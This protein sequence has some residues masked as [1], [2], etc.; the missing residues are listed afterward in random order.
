MTD[1]IV[2]R[3]TTAIFVRTNLEQFQDRLLAEGR[4]IRDRRRSDIEELRLGLAAAEAAALEEQARR[5]RNQITRRQR[6]VVQ[7]ENI[8][9]ALEAGF[10]PMPRLP[11]V[12]L[13]HVLGLIP[14]SALLA[15]GAAKETGLF[16]VFR[17][18]DGRNTDRTGWPIEWS[19]SRRR[20]RD[21]I[22]VGM[23]GQ[24]MFPLAWWK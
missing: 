11:A 20:S 21:P 7:A 3:P 16:E 13:H 4:Q 14:P 8:V 2:A 22:L 24:E 19:R 9:G 12:R 23:I 5:Y 18:V 1:V 15:L 10:V 6:D 17:V